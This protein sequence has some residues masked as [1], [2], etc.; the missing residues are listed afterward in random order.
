MIKKY[1]AIVLFTL[2]TGMAFAQKPFDVVNFERTN[3]AIAKT[4]ED[5]RDDEQNGGKM[6]LIIVNTENLGYELFFD[7]DGSSM[8]GNI[9]PV[10]RNGGEYY[11]YVPAASRFVNI[12]SNSPSHTEKYMFPVTI[13]GGTTYHMVI[14]GNVTKNVI[15]EHKSS[16]QYLKIY[17]SPKNASVKVDDEYLSVDHT[18]GYAE[19]EVSVGKHSVRITCEDYYPESEDNIMVGDNEVTKR[20]TLRPNFG[21][22]KVTGSNVSGATVVIDGNVQNDN[23][24]NTYKAK[25]KK[26][27]VVIQKKLYKKVQR[28]VTVRDG[29]TS[30]ID[31]NLDPNYA[32]VTFKADEGS[33][34]RI[35]ND[36]YNR[37]TVSDD[38]ESGRYTVYVDRLYHR[39]VS[40]VYNINPSMNGNTIN[41][42]SPVPIYGSLNIT[43][44]PPQADITL[45]GKPTQ[46]QTS[47][48]INNVLIGPHS[49]LLTKSGYG[50][51]STNVTVEENQ[52]TRVSGTLQNK[53][54]VQFTCSTPSATLYIDGERVDSPNSTYS[55]TIG[56]HN[57]RCTARDCEDYVSNIDVQIEGQLVSINPKVIESR[58]EI[59]GYMDITDVKFGSTDKDLKPN[60]N[61][62]QPLY[63]DQVYYLSPQI[64]YNGMCNS[65]KTVQFDINVYTSSGVKMGTG[66]YTYSSSGTI[67]PGAG[68]TWICS[69]WGRST[70]GTYTPGRYKFEFYYNRRL[71]KTVYAEIL[72]RNYLYVE[73]YKNSV[74]RSLQREGGYTN[75]S[76]RTDASDYTIINVPKWCMVTKN[77]NS[78]FTVKYEPN[79]QHSERKATMHV[80]AAGK[81]VDVVLTQPAAPKTWWEKT[82]S[83]GDY[84]SHFLNPVLGYNMESE[85]LFYGLSYTW[86]KY[87]VGFRGSFLYN[88]DEGASIISADLS[89]RLSTKTAA[90]FQI[91]GGVGLMNGDMI[92]DAGIRLGWDE[93]DNWDWSLAVWDIT[94]GSYFSSTYGITP[95]IALGLGLPLSPVL[96]IGYGFAEVFDADEMSSVSHH[97]LDFQ[98]GFVNGDDDLIYGLQYS[99]IPEHFGIY[100]N[101]FFGNSFTGTLGLACRLTNEDTFL[102]FDLYGGFGYSSIEGSH[103][104]GEAGMR[105]GFDNSGDMGLQAFDINAGA[106]FV[107]NNV[108]PYVGVGWGILLVGGA[109]VGGAM[110]G[111]L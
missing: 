71:I 45:D 97:Y 39:T 47:T 109:I 5:S 101:M 27:D 70:S 34:I 79:T 51:Y 35:N 30:E 86:H 62:G 69:G 93:R 14:K 52:T 22:I 100:L 8:A 49:I 105:I 19:A 15:I 78:N 63:A 75:L 36:S 84:S 50:S 68:N 82:A 72:D 107:G 41:L 58:F 43:S 88:F 18:T 55:L 81:S 3:S 12:R 77:A 61:Y 1:L 80:V 110:L 74:S 25:S 60:I 66:D 24:P 42:P 9:I 92:Y 85:N 26:H 2:L 65:D 89:M 16:T 7:L 23:A 96:G 104:A 73:G 21:Y 98:I 32:R 56:N 64:V 57:I 94:I 37:S 33:T 67:K 87:R 48:T 4:G 76:V 10:P 83:D 99:Y 11:V 53:Y 29:E 91:F 38:F 106:L 103:F 13:D 40:E 102:D 44:T 46:R 31:V 28:Q 54:N 59:Y 6:A 90:D 17:V 108:V 111:T 95:Y 20:Y